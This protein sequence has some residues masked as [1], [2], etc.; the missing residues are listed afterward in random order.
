MLVALKF[1]RVIETPID[2]R[3]IEMF[4]KHGYSRRIC[5]TC[6]YFDFQLC[7]SYCKIIGDKV[8]IF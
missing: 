8:R 2:R 5:D 3:L 1:E 7:E 6:K 4:A